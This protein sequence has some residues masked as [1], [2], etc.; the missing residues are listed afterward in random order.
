MFALV[1]S[2]CDSKKNKK[3]LILKMLTKSAQACTQIG[4]GEIF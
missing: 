1:Y 2:L 4:V 3:F